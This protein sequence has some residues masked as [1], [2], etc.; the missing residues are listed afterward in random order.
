M[1]HSTSPEVQE[2]DAEATA[3]HI[4]AS[5]DASMHDEEDQDQDVA[6]VET[7]VEVDAVA[8]NS[9]PVEA[10][11]KQ[12][13]KLEELFADVESD[14]EFPSSNTQEIKISSSPDAPASP[15]LVL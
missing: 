11:E 2:P 8:E 9:A 7:S 12:E 15:M 6:M 14:E 13:V 10:Q 5:D 1:P 4:E 3:T